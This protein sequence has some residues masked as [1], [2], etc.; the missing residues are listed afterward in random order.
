MMGEENPMKRRHLCLTQFA[1]L[2]IATFAPAIFAQSLSPASADLKIKSGTLPSEH[3]LSSFR[4]APPRSRLEAKIAD[5][6]WTIVPV[7]DDITRLLELWAKSGEADQ[8][9]VN[10]LLA[11]I[12]ITSK[13][14]EEELIGKMTAAGAQSP[15]GAAAFVEKVRDTLD[16]TRYAKVDSAIQ[17][18]LDAFGDE[19][20]G[21]I[22]TGSS[23]QRYL[24]LK[25]TGQGSTSYR[26]LFS[27][28]DISFV[29]KKAQDAAR[30][31]NSI[32]EREG[33]GA[34]KVRGM[35][36][37]S[38]RNIRGIDLTALDML[39][40]EKFLGESGI[41]SLKPEM[42]EKGAVIAE[43]SATGMAMRPSPLRQF[44]ESKKSRMIADLID[45]KAVKATVEKFGALTLVGSCERQIVTAHGGWQN[46]SDPEKVKYVLRQRLAL[47][48]SGAMKN[49]A[50]EGVSASQATLVK[51]RELKNKATL[52]PEELQWVSNLRAQNIDLAF[53]EIPHKLGP[54][55]DAAESSGRSLASNPEARRMMNELTTGFALMRDRIIDIPEDQIIA[56]LK[57]LA[58]E[59][60]EMYS[61]LYTSFQQS[62]DLVQALDQWVASGG[63]REAFLDML[64]KAENRLARLQQVIARKAKKAKAPEAK[65]LT[66]MEEM[67]GTDLGDTFLMKMAKNPAAKKVVL[68][69]MVATGG[70]VCL[71]ALYNSWE[72]GSFKDDLSWAV[73]GIIDFLPG[74][75]GAKRAYVEGMDMTTVLL[76]VKDALYLTP[77]WPIVLA[78]DMLMIAVDMGAAYKVQMQQAGLV[79]VLVYNGQFD[80]NGD[81]A[82]FIKLTLPDGSAWAPDGLKDWLF[83]TK[84]VR[85]KHAIE[86]KEYFINDLSS[87]STDLLDKAF[88]P[89]DPVT[90]Q[91]RLAAEQQMNAINAAEINDASLKG[92]LF[93][94]SLAYGR[95]LFGFE[96]VC[97]KSP[98][99]WCRVFELLKKKIG[100]RREVVKEKVMVPQL[101]EMAEA[102]ATQLNAATATEAKI[103]KLQALFESARGSELFESPNGGPK[104]MLS[105]KLKVRADALA[106]EVSTDTAEDR[107]MKRGKYWLQAHGAYSRIWKW[108]KD[109]KANIAT[110]TGWDKAQVFQF[111]WTGDFEDDE[112]KA[113]QSR[114]GFASELSKIQKAILKIKGKQPSPTDVI[115]KEAFAIL[116]DVVFRWRAALDQTDAA[117]PSE[118]S[119][120]FTEYDEAVEKVKEL[121][122]GSKEFQ[123]LLDKGA[124]LIKAQDSLNLDKGTALELKFKDPSLVKM[125]SDGQLSLSWSST[126]NGDFS[127]NNK[128]PKTIYAPFSPEPVTVT[129]T[130]ERR[131]TSM[132]KGSLSAKMAV[133]VPENF[134]TLT[135]TPPQPKPEQIV[136]IEAAIPERFFGGKPSFHYRWSCEN[137]KIDDFDRTRTP[138]TA[139]KTGNAAV[140]CELLVDGN[141]GRTATLLRKTVRFN[142]TPGQTP[143]PTPTPTATPTAT[144]TP[145]GSPTPAEDIDISTVEFG[146]NVPG[147]WDGG[148]NPKGFSFKRQVAKTKAPG[149]CQWEGVV[150]SE[151]WGKI[152]DWRGPSEDEID[153]KIT[154][155]TASNKAWGKT[156]KVREI[157]IS[158]FKGKLIESSIAWYYGS[159]SDAGYRGESISA[160]AVGWLY[161]G[162]HTVEVGYNVGGGGCWT[163]T[164]RP[165][166]MSQGTAAQAEA[167]AIINSLTLVEKNDFKKV[168]YTGPK[169]DGSDMPK[170]ILVPSTI[171]K[172]KVGDTVRV[173][174]T[175]ENAAAEDSPF[176]Y[177]WGGEFVGKETP[178]GKSATSVTIKATKPGKFPLSVSVEGARYFLGSASL[179]YEVA[180]YK[181]R[182]E[183]TGKATAKVSVG[184]TADFKATLTVDGKP[185]SGKFVYRWQ[186]MTDVT[187]SKEEGQ[188]PENTAKFL[189][190]GKAK[191]WVE[192]LADEGG[193]M[194]P[195]ADSNQI[196]LDIVLPKLILT[197]TPQKGVVGAEVKAKVT[198]NVPELTEIDY[199]WETTANGK[200]LNE[201]QD[202]SEITFAPQD[203]KVVT[204]TVNARVPGTGDDLGKQTATFTAEPVTVAVTVLGPEGPKP[205]VWREGV[206]LVTLEKEIAVHQFVN[207]RADVTPQVD[208]MRYEWTVNEDCHFAGNNITQATRAYRSQTGMCEASVVVRN[209]DGLELGRGAGSFSATVSQ[210]DLDKAKTMGGTA[211]KVTNAKGL[212]SKGQLDEAITLIETVVKA[213]PKN[214][215]AAVLAN[216]WKADRTTIQTQLGKVKALIDQQKFTEASKELSVAK[217]L[218]NL[219]PPVV[220]IDTELN[221]KAAAF[222]SG[223]NNAVFE[224]KTAIDQRDYKRALKQCSEIRTKFK[225][226]A[227][228][229]QTVKGYE[230]FARSHEAEKE[231]LRGVMKQGEGKYNAGDYDGALTDFAQ[232]WVNFNTYWNAEI[233]PEPRYYEN[234]RNETLK[235]RDRIKLIMPQIKQA[236]DNPVFDRRQ[237]D[238]AAALV[239]E[240]LQLQPGNTV[241]QGYKAAIAGKLSGGDI[242]TK[243][244]DAIKRGDQLATERKWQDAVKAYDEAIKADPANS[245]GYRLRGRAKREAGD[246][247]G[248]LSDF[249]KAI[250]L[251]PNNYQ[252]W[253]GRGLTKDKSGDKSGA[254]ADFD[255]GIAINPNYAAGYIYRA[256]VKLDL[257]DW[258]GAKADY[259]RALSIDP[260]N[261]ASYSNRAYAK[262]NLADR[263]GAVADYTKAIELNPNNAIAYNNRGHEKQMLG[264]F[265]GALADFEKALQLNPDYTT[266]KNNIAKLKEQMGSAIPTTGKIL[267]GQYRIVANKNQFIVTLTVEGARFTGT[268][269][270]DKIMNGVISG[271][272][273]S[274]HLTAGSWSM[275]QD[276]KGTIQGNKIVGTFTGAPYPI[277]KEYWPW[278]LDLTPIG[279]IPK[280]S[281][282]PGTSAGNSTARLGT[283]WSIREAGLPGRWVRR[284]NS[285]T[286]DAKWDNGAVAVMTITLNGNKIRISRTDTAGPGL[287]TAVYDG[288]LFDN[289]TIR[290]T[291]V[292]KCPPRKG[293]IQEEW[294]A[295][296][297]SGI[298][299]PKPTPTPTPA[300]PPAGTEAK[301]FDNTNIGGVYNN[302]TAPTQF[303]ISRPHMITLVVT[304]HWNNASG[305][306][307]PGTIG[308]R[309]SDGKMYGPWQTTGKP[310][311]GGVPNAYWEAY[312]K[313]V[314]PAGTYTIV[315]SS[316][317][318]WAQNSGSRSQGHAWVRGYPAG[319]A[320]AAPPFTM[321][322]QTSAPA[323]PPQA[324]T[325]GRYVTAILENRSGEAVHIFPEGDTFGPGNK[326]APGE[327]RE[328]RV[329]MPSTGRIKFTAGRNGQVITTKF[330]D[331]D[332]DSLTRFPR[333]TFDGRALLIVTGLR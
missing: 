99:K 290:G 58:G 294:Q 283:A 221:Q 182:L 190:P 94:E 262:G 16:R 203:T 74:G 80:Y 143:T 201:S 248:S 123:E 274:F 133:V 333:V 176:K 51:L 179:E 2:C 162:R 41:G 206:G 324:S 90:Q 325:Q 115:D 116:S 177:D 75:I 257:K 175:V 265:Q 110:R 117:T 271:N 315:D 5:S 52:T 27:D 242:K 212:V 246:F 65:A 4:S 260:K 229:E 171:E 307:L 128:D 32:L 86:G 239:N 142:V 96:T 68:G 91:L 174:V 129:V 92:A 240:V 230:D 141:D 172:L 6:V 213:D 67:L 278:E 95:W 205:Q 250:E 323:K 330:W 225:L 13:K 241:A 78:G 113:N 22:R 263:N 209:K 19:L 320:S 224:I 326:I 120:Y 26:T 122:A 193:R 289:N 200:L 275:G 185:A 254:M 17:E 243:S 158:G 329:L 61:M 267:S 73:L 134:L 266:A 39:E 72:R 35:D 270:A 187:F 77:A 103:D 109:I 145:T 132:A 247:R 219:Y 259:D 131:G 100:D 188:T 293:D 207:L 181:V 297:V 236:V 11:K 310:G 287:C 81:S 216:K 253:L 112:R 21:V 157:S 304:Y 186:P 89:E 82:K 151:V 152:D 106:K 173:S 30:M 56:K 159:W 214:S 53:K 231:R 150:N 18:V 140:T 222:N 261:A 46:L 107:T 273:V 300:A 49:I 235:R 184:G 55:I 124:E 45:D 50:E 48:E 98:E 299:A 302:P 272:S 258:A 285:D 47:T 301:I 264:D 220:A 211:E 169:L 308:L 155:I 88:I 286:W 282:T 126:A 197:L 93:G 44:V 167:N 102:K 7:Q 313:V 296:I 66:A 84:A 306:T 40:P 244:D 268:A 42:M 228:T 168:P 210:A 10:R 215:E 62:K 191:V 153:R 202:A 23:G 136:G 63:T 37:G 83:Q 12:D 170:V 319:T 255:R 314:I 14:A 60:K 34:L 280:V 79:D 292:A 194:V 217:N 311:Q 43:Q 38:L 9:I 279:T 178:A 8:I 104:V 208:G 160:S 298:T 281:P 154:D 119:S 309:G 1:A 198:T 295:T 144:P 139:P 276:Y 130:V 249:N 114:A 135:L 121:Y 317:A 127:P 252:S 146:G 322:S 87:A 24:Q 97:N 156:T 189:V 183:R 291:L 25:G 125:Y 15:G 303:S 332:P 138:V 71:K 192:V 31:L 148:K 69:A 226:L 111:K 312:P 54:I 195:L 29:G 288:T 232:L 101:I 321:K 20:E 76:F 318:T 316:P 199:R 163:N 180:D 223:V 238:S 59:N 3:V 36:L 227:A 105:A 33:M 64:V 70:A 218:H 328:V 164:H 108:G 234:L 57:S 149:E 85:V 331:G 256:S 233:D 118:G 237:L 305:S 28:D 165:F 196:E 284:G 147:I 277:G 251:D 137:C 161:K 245:N 327:K 204:I 269:G 166:L